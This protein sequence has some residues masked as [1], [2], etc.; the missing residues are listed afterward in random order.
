MSENGVKTGEEPVMKNV[1]IQF[2]LL[3]NLHPFS[4]VTDF[5]RQIMKST[6]Y[7]RNKKN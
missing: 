2:K 3:I 6:F 7:P 4:A 1:V 5:R